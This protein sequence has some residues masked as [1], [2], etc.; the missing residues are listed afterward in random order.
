M[1]AV[2]ASYSTGH[3]HEFTRASAS[4]AFNFVN[5]YMQLNYRA[6]SLNDVYPRIQRWQDKI[7]TVTEAMAGANASQMKLM[8]IALHEEVVADWWKLADWLIMRYNDG[9]VN[10]PTLGMVS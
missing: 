8:Q 7:D 10:Y 6:M 5:N 1:G 4:W 9:R 3:G 2:S